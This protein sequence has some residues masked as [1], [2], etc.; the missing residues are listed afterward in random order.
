MDTRNVAQKKKDVLKAL[1][2]ELGLVSPACEKSGV[3]R[4]SFYSYVRKDAKFA[5]AV[6][7][8][9]NV[10]LDFVENKLFKQIKEGS[11]AAI[12]F[13]LKCKGKGRGYIEQQNVNLTSKDLKITFDRE[14]QAL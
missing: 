8:I 3:S 1:K 14:D 2:A 9:S 10:T 6:E 13:Y 11:V 5:A 7:D 4:S 12:C